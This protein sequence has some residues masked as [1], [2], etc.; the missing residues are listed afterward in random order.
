MSVSRLE[1]DFDDE[2]VC[3]LSDGMM[4][5]AHLLPLLALVPSA[6]GA[7]RAAPSFAARPAA[8]STLCGIVMSAD[9]P[10][11]VQHATTTVKL[12]EAT[13]EA[14]AAAAQDVEV[15]SADD[16]EQML[17][18]DTLVLLDRAPAVDRD[19][20]VVPI[21]PTPA[22]DRDASVVQCARLRCDARI[23]RSRSQRLLAC[24]LAG[25]ARPRPSSTRCS[26]TGKP[27]APPG[28]R[29]RFRLPSRRRSVR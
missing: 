15:L 9:P 26:G 16:V 1:I 4:K 17:P 20:S 22:G 10:D 14:A 6:A 5:A 18:P 28:R 12:D 13:V 3:Q 24:A 2:P 11:A 19:V 7:L 25:T 21:D 29:L 8:A 27:P 23:A